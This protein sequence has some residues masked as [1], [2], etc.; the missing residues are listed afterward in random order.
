MERDDYVYICVHTPCHTFGGQKTLFSIGSVL[1][2]LVL[3]LGDR[4]L[5]LQDYFCGQTSLPK[6]SFIAA[7]G[8]AHL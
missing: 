6:E 8:G 2:T 3:R 5:Y 1:G 4:H 7:H